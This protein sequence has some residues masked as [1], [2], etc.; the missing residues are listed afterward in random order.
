[1]SLS[2]TQIVPTGRECHFA[3]DEIIVSK[4]DVVR[5]L[6]GSYRS[7]ATIINGATE[8]MARG[9]QQLHDAE[10]ARLKL[11][12]DFEA[13]IKVVV[14]NVAAAATEARA[15]AE[16]LSRTADQTSTHSHTVAAAAE[17]ASRG[18]DSVA[19]AAE[20]ITAT[21]GEIERQAFETSNISAQAV[22]AVERTNETV[23]T[24]SDASGQITRVVKLIND[25]SRQTRLLALNAAIE[26]A[27]VGEA[28]KNFAVVAAEMKNLAVEVGEATAEIE[29]Q[30]NAIQGATEQ[31]VT[32]IDDIGGTVRRGNALSK[33]VI[34][35]V[36][37]QRCANAEIN[38]SIHDAAIGTREV[39]QTITTVSGAMRETGDAAGQMPGA[40]DELSRMAEVLRSDVDR[41]LRVIRAGT[42]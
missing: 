17:E 42:A 19:A 14:D 10:R 26:A 35:A 37:E 15:T 22:E 9:T 27:R 7:A 38:C 3:D 29:M 16:G 12:D 32:A 33:T 5:G 18:M 30:V 24:L 31:V 28:G 6:L 25:I 36:A 13:A 34:S 39:T 41:F 23:F 8:Q 21:I 4:T 20:E 2:R 11:A 40:A 1:M